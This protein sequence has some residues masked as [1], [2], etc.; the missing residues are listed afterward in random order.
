MA[1]SAS[2]FI[3]GLVFGIGLTL[4]QMVNP[5]KVLAFLDIT[6]NW[7]PSLA[8]VMGG[9]LVTTLIGYRLILRR[10]SPVFDVQFSLPT[11]TQ[12]DRPLAVG[13]ILFG[14]G[15]GLVGL[16]PGPAIA[17]ISIGGTKTLAFLFTMVLG[18]FLYDQTPVQRIF[19]R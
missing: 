14:L 3:A 9:A 12:I 15:W 17:S 13:A 19:T 18:A 4:S 2:A 5:Q 7:D 8:L 10:Q 16:C 6:G 11:N 1:K